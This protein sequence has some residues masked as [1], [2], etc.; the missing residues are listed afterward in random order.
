MNG[1]AH[2]D[3]CQIALW[4]SR[5]ERRRR[6]WRPRRGGGGKYPATVRQLSGNS[7]V[8]LGLSLTRNCNRIKI[9]NT[10]KITQPPN[11]RPILI[12]PFFKILLSKKF[13]TGYKWLLPKCMTAP[14]Q[15]RL[16]TVTSAFVAVPCLLQKESILDHR[17]SF[18]HT[19][20]EFFAH[21][22]SRP[23]QEKSRLSP[24]RQNLAC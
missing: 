19:F 8:A 4:L 23:F 24:F 3:I 22:V 20:S 12:S 14:N 9:V 13:A 17:F 11:H 5:C 10:S 16:W 7:Q 15:S 21:D 18:S 2:S 1:W 6:R